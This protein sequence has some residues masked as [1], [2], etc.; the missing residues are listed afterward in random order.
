MTGE[1]PIPLKAAE[2]CLEARHEDHYA[3]ELF[4]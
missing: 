1:K 2:D 3:E 4:H